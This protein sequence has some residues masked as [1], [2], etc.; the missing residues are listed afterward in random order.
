MNIPT[1]LTTHSFGKQNTQ[2][3]EREIDIRG[4][5]RG[6]GTHFGIDNEK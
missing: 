2:H 4:Q 3:T 1:L 6:C 5:G